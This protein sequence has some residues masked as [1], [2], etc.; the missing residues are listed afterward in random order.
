MHNYY[1]VPMF[2]SDSVQTVQATA[3]HFIAF[4]LLLPIDAMQTNVQVFRVDHGHLKLHTIP[5]YSNIQHVYTV[6]L[7]STRSYIS[8]DTQ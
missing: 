2:N 1:S 7:P 3:L 5:V 4:T 6:G 8:S